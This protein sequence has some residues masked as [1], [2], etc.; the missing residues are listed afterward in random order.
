L[1]LAPGR[2]I[3]T[4]QFLAI[5]WAPDA[6]VAK[7]AGV[8]LPTQADEDRFI[9]GL[10][11]RFRSMPTEQKDYLR[12]AELRLVDFNQV[13][14]GTIKTRAL[15]AADIK[16]NVHSPAD[17]WREARQVENNSAYGS[18]YYELYRSEAIGAVLHANGVAM[19]LYTLGS[20]FDR[21]MRN[22]QKFVTPVGVH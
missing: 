20:E 1:V 17:V 5:P 19:N 3:S 11:T 8:A 4:S 10:R 21:S 6:L 7:A 13:Y 12:R 9:H 16:K 18:R 14:N 2:R 15:V 22:M